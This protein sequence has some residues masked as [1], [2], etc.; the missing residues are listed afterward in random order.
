MRLWR[1]IRVAIYIKLQLRISSFLLTHFFQD[2]LTRILSFFFYSPT[3]HSALSLLLPLPLFFPHH[4]PSPLFHLIFL[5]NVLFSY[6]FTSLSFF[7]S[8]LTLLLPS[9]FPLFSCR[10]VL[11]LSLFT[12]LPP[13]FFLPF[14]LPL[15][16][17]VLMPSSSPSSLL[18]LSFPLFLSSSYSPPPPPYPEVVASCHILLIAWGLLISEA[19]FWWPLLL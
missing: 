7:F 18:Y 3:S 17:L 6:S 19:D 15:P 14:F 12:S 13:S 11:P 9:P 8:F 4:F 10:S 5:F 16:P 1:V 2:K